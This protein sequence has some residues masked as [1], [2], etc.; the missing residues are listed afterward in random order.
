MSLASWLNC[1]KHAVQLG[2]WTGRHGDSSA[3]DLCSAHCRKVTASQH[4]K[5][6]RPLSAFRRLVP[7]P[8]QGQRV[9]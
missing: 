6:A 3:T 5:A 9:G 4:S 2:D 1:S 7:Q 8:C